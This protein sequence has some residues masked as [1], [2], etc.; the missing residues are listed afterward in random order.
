MS[1]VD[2][3]LEMIINI[4]GNFKEDFNVFKSETNEKLEE[5]ERLD[6]IEQSLYRIENEQPKDITGI[7]K[8]INS[9]DQRPRT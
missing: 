1:E 5:L 2:K 4:L 7:L 3:K 6:R 8:Q 9:K